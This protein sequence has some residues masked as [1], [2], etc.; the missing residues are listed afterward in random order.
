MKKGIYILAILAIGLAAASHLPRPPGWNYSSGLL[1]LAPVGLV[2]AI[3]ALRWMRRNRQPGTWFFWIAAL[4]CAHASFAA[5]G[6]T[7]EEAHGMAREATCMSNLKQLGLAALEYCEDYDDKFP[8]ANSW[9]ESLVI[10]LKR[11][12]AAPYTGSEADSRAS[13]IL[14]CPSAA[15]ESPGPDYAINA[16][17]AGIKMS[18]IADPDQTPLFFDS[19]PGPNRAGGWE[20]LPSPPRHPWGKNIVCFAD[21][22]CGTVSVSQV[23][24]LRW[25]ANR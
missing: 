19:I 25:K 15:G 16:A 11:K 17:V 22:H 2:L 5:L 18:A 6:I 23:G 4:V 1:K 3:A 9:N 21:G 8:P 12:W 7:L 10:H 14:N 24:E 13:R 20:L